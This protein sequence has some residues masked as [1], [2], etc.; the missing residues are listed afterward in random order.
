MISIL[1][2]C[3]QSEEKEEGAEEETEMVQEAA[4]VE[5]FAL[6]KGKLSSSLQVP[7]ELVAFR[8]V[9]I[10]ARVSSYIKR[11]YVDV[12][13]EV[14]EG[15]LLAV[16]E[17][18]ELNA[19]V[20]AAES[21]LKSQEALY[22]ASKANYDRVVDA[23]KTQGAI[24][25]TTLEQALAKK[26][27]D[28]AQ[29][30]AARAS[31]REVSDMRKYLEI[32]APFGGII[33]LRNTSTGAYVGPAGKGSELPLFVLTEQKRLRLVVS[34]PETYTGYVDANDEVSFTVRTFPDRKFTGKVKRMAGALD[35]K[36]RSER[37]EVDVINADRK[38]LPGMVAEVTIPLPTRT[39]TFIVP[40]TAVVN[41]TSGIFVIR[42]AGGKAEWVPIEK[43]L[44]ADEKI[45]IFGKLN[46]GDQLVLTASEEVRNGLPVP[47][48]KTADTAIQ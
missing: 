40:K 4:P 35:K 2:G 14:S 44:E 38:L 9:D 6:K 27:S 3:H 28:Y 17:A 8:D 25:Q 22:I 47:Q 11:L 5:V 18:P 34:V 42:V 21:R 46:E 20:S 39:A 7:G 24:A 23:A 26:N 43:G 12:G 29:L 32:R 13:S 19:Q 36:L 45:E 41:S 15:Q 10:Y 16:A 33:S 48:V 30:E 1:T 31:F 37:V